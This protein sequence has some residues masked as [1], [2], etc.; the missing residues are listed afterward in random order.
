M[1]YIDSVELDDKKE[2]Y[3]QIN[4]SRVSISFDTEPVN[5]MF[6]MTFKDLKKL[7]RIITSA[8]KYRTDE[9]NEELN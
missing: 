5:I 9:L 3:V 6:T 1:S 8:V 2:I 4:D 7:E